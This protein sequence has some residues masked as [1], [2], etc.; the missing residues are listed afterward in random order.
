MGMEVHSNTTNSV[1]EQLGYNLVDPLGMSTAVKLQVL[2]DVVM[3]AGANYL[4]DQ[5]NDYSQNKT[6]EE[7]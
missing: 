7:D 4:Y 2:P 6:D 1:S 5:S 3:L